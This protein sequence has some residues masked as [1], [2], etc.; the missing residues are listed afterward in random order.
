LAYDYDVIVIGS[1]IGGLTAGAFLA[2]AG[3]KV[4][5]LE[6]HS[7]IGGYAHH[8][9]RNGYTFESGIHSVPMGDNG[10]I[11]HLLRLLKVDDQITT[12][13]F[14]EMYA[15]RTPEFFLGVPQKTED[16]RAFLKDLSAADAS[17]VDRFFADMRG[18]Y[19]A[20]VGPQF[21][22]EHAYVPENAAF[23]AK[24]HNHSYQSYLDGVFTSPTIKTLLGGQWPYGGTPPERGGQ[25]FY[26]MMCAFHTF[27]GSHFC[28][29]GFSTLA[30]ALASAI[31][32]NGGEV[33]TGAEV[34][35]IRGTGK[36]ASHVLT[37]KGEEYSTKAVVSN[38]SP[39][40]LH[41]QLLAEDLRGRF[42]LRRLGNLRPSIST[43]MVYLGMKPGF[44]ATHPR[45]IV[46]EYDSADYGSMFERV[47]NNQKD[48]I[49]HLIS[50]RTIEAT[51]KPTL[52]LM[53]FAAKSLSENWKSDKMRYADQMLAKAEKLYPGLSDF[54]DVVEVGSPATCERYT[55]NT[56]GSI[57]GF[58]NTADMYGEAKMPHTTHLDNVYQVGHW[59]KPGCGV[60]NVMSNGY[61]GSKVILGRD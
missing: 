26:M 42:T 20:Y 16:I 39:Y 17:G 57:Y 41:Q 36:T 7:K 47:L 10:L 13:E 27:D 28:E 59:G 53:N 5:V 32:A 29:G 46:F 2:R 23:M 24:F 6:K 40:L 60:W 21:D 14:P 43:L 11:R 15:V 19:D 45:S 37:K 34:T 48:S 55:A 52:T 38:I 56:E 8:F 44:E 54:I 33:K 18:L 31:R 25:L 12:I 1:G 49:D 58:E 3:K 50:L 30:D 51:D 22:Y 9:N 61:V 35:A 4:L